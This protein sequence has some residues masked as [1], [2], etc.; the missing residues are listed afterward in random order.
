MIVREKKFYKTI[1]AI[2]LP[3]SVQSFISFMVNFLDTLMLGQLGEDVLSGANLAGQ[4]FFITMLTITGVSE[5]SNVLISQYYGKGDIKS[6][7]KIYAIAYRAVFL[8]GLIACIIATFFSNQFMNIYSTEADIIYQGSKYLK[9]MAIGYIPYALASC[10]V[11]TLRAV[12]STKIAMVVYGISFLVNAFLNYALIFGKFGFPRLEIQGA[13]IATTISRFVELFIVLW[14]IFKIDEKIKLKFEH[15]K[16]IDKSIL[17]NY[18][19]NAIPILI[20]EILWVLGSTSISV[21]FGRMGKSVVSA[22]AISSVMFQ[23]VSVFLF[24]IASASLVIIGNVIGEG[25]IQKAYI[26]AKTFIILAIGLG[27]ISAL[28]V[29]FSKDLVI[30]LYNITPETVI[31]AEDILKASSFIL[32]FQA[33]A[34]LTGIGVLRGGGDSKFVLITEII[35]LWFIALPLGVYGAFYLELPVFWIYILTR[36]DEIIKSFVFIIRILFSK[37]AKD[38][39]NSL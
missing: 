16:K 15:L 14:Y 23:L 2:A 21:I 10:S 36:L 28:C 8:F 24:G 17:K 35:S 12:H 37:W 29:Y 27:L 32:F 1:L 30:S 6:I 25:K 34:I 20:N 19:K 38:M 33:I 9:V 26:Y 5:G 3:I 4:M 22:N 18:I 11:T 13:A 7:H 39:T 31:I